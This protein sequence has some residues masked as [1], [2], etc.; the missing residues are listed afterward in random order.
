M[1]YVGEGSLTKK[2]RATQKFIKDQMTG[3]VDT[4]WRI[5]F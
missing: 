3:R 1:I 2:V 5:F 4:P